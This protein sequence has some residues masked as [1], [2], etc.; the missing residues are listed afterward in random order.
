MEKIV[1]INNYLTFA[2]SWVAQ[3]CGERNDRWVMF[4]EH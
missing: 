1:I 4:T 3:A 2:E